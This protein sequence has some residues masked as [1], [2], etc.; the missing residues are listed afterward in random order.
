MPEYKVDIPYFDILIDS[1]DIPNHDMSI[2][3]SSHVHWG[4]W[5]NP[6]AGLVSAPE[7]FKAAERL[8]HFLLGYAE[9]HDGQNIIDVGCGFGG[10]LAIINELYSDSSLFGLNIDRRQIERAKSQVIPSNDNLLRF[11]V[12]SANS[13]PYED[14]SADLITAVECIFHFDRPLFFNEV[15]RVLKPGGKLIFSDYVPIGPALP[16]LV[17]LM[18][19]GKKSILPTFGEIDILCSRGKYNRLAE[20]TG[21]SKLVDVDITKNTLPTYP[22]VRQQMKNGTTGNAVLAKAFQ[23]SITYMEILS[24]LRLLKYR[25]MGYRKP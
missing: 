17:S 10:T 11:D 12:G 14:G 18:K 6:S 13:L 9:I 24:I 4:Y 2:A 5:E 15:F 19:L 23:E 3:F 20:K 22:F 25:I 7:Y 8:V 21:F 16:L 1:I